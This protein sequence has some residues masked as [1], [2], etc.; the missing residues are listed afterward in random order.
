M[1]TDE[2]VVA[3]Q[4]HYNQSQGKGAVPVH[5]GTCGECGIRNAPHRVI[6]P[7][8]GKLMWVCPICEEKFAAQRPRLPNGQLW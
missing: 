3:R 7:Q 4:M 1:S 2:V 5:L 8:T 6:H